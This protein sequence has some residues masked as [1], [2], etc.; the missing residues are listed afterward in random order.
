MVKSYELNGVGY[1]VPL[2][3]NTDDYDK[4]VSWEYEIQRE[5]KNEKIKLLDI[6]MMS[7]FYV[8]LEDGER[9]L[10]YFWIGD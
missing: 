2:E 6:H 3:E 10:L 5:F 4:Y 1:F 9:G 8:E 7:Q